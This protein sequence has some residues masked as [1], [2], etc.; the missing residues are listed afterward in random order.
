MGRLLKVIV[1]ILADCLKPLVLATRA[2]SRPV[3]RMWRL[4]ELRAAT[5]GRIPVSTQFDGPIEVAGTGNVFLGEQCR[6]GVGVFFETNGNGE[7]LLGKRV[8]IN[9]GG[10]IVSNSRVSI[11]DFALIGEMVSIRDANHGVDAGQLICEQAQR[12]REIVIGTDVWIGRGTC[13]LQGVR[14]G[15]GAVIGANSVVTHDI[16]DGSIFAG[17]PAKQ[18]GIRSLRSSG[19]ID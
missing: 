4:A 8:R 5:N 2:V 16:P 9:R 14:I 13:I 10:T 11:G 19:G 3:L 15:D 12:S 7:I 1:H 6:L 18:I 17:L